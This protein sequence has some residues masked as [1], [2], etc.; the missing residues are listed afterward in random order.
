MLLT[1]IV[2]NYNH[3][4]LLPRALEAI[5]SQTPRPDEILVVDDASTDDSLSVLAALGRRAPSL[6]VIRHERNLGAI[7]ALNRGVAEARG[8]YI[9]LGSADDLTLPGLFALGL[10]LLTAHPAAAFACAECRIVDTTGAERGIRPLARPAGRTGYVP[11]TSVPELLRRIDYWA[12]TSTAVLRRDLVGAAGGL[13]PAF[14]SLAD[15]VL[16]RRLALRHGF[17]FAPR[18][19]AEW[20]L[21]SD[22]L[23]QSTVAA[24]ETMQRLLEAVRERLAADA[25]FPP[26]YADLLARR[27][28]F[29][30]AQVT[31]RSIPL[32]LDVID[33][34]APD[35]TVDRAVLHAALAIPGRA[36]RELALAWL[37]LRRP[38]I[39]PLAVVQTA[40]ARRLRLPARQSSPGGPR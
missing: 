27:L 10:D 23:S 13:D 16:V 6:R 24:P 14:G 8:R 15:S 1:A 40:V 30:A 20:T 39:S 34:A 26:W 7:A 4:H 32:R 19:V 29:A 11:A 28:R 17:C 21:R 35:G 37:I 5:A 36:G 2:P 33:A 22:G 25:D 9:Y 38:P 31:L 12:H 18:V 3:G